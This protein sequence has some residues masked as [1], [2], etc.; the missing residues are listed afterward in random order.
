MS[1]YTKLASR[2]FLEGEYTFRDLERTN[3][4]NPIDC[5]TVLTI[6]EGASR[7]TE[8]N[9]ESCTAINTP[10]S[11]TQFAREAE[12]IEPHAS[13]Y[14][15]K[16]YNL[17]DSEKYEL[18]GLVFAIAHLNEAWAVVNGGNHG[19]SAGVNI[20]NQK[21]ADAILEALKTPVDRANYLLAKIRKEAK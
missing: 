8:R 5:P 9:W 7:P 19:T 10:E 11:L 6:R 17:S 15:L 18:I 4:A 13:A 3:W 16:P 14:D 20:R 1:K 2:L 21:A 12:A